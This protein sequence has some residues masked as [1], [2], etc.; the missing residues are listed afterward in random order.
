MIPSESENPAS[1]LARCVKAGTISLGIAP[2]AQLDSASVF[3]TEGW[4]FESLL[5]YFAKVFLVKPL[6][7]KAPLH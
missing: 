4:G 2:V 1:S 6:A 5:V 7:S 3:G